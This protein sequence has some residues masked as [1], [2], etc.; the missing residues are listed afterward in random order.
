MRRKGGALTRSVVPAAALAAILLMV[1]AP[2]AAW[3]K[4][5]PD[6]LELLRWSAGK[7]PHVPTEGR[8]TV[9]TWHEHGTEVEVA[10]VQRSGHGQV[11][12]EVVLP[13]SRRGRLSLQ[14]GRDRWSYDPHTHRPPESQSLWAEWRVDRPGEASKVRACPPVLVQSAARAARKL[15]ELPR[16]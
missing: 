15:Q 10:D 3:A 12:S 16:A 5:T 1:A 14:S 11:R 6:G 7:Y 4:G 13:R 8:Q 2:R 9:I